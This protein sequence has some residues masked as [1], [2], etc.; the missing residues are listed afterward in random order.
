MVIKFSKNISLRFF[1]AMCL[2]E[3]SVLSGASQQMADT[4]DSLLQLIRS[5]ANSNE[6]EYEKGNEY[7]E[8]SYMISDPVLNVL[9]DLSLTWTL[10][11]VNDVYES[12]GFY[13]SGSWVDDGATYQSAVYSGR[14][15]DC[16]MQDFICPVLGG[17]LT[18]GYGYRESYKRLHKGIDISVKVGDVVRAALP[19]I[20][21]RIGYEPGGYGH[22][23]ILVHSNGMET[24]YAHLSGVTARLGQ[25]VY[26]GDEIARGGN[27]GNSTG[28][29]L[30]FEVRKNGKVLDPM[31]VFEDLKF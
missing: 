20:V 3:A 30:H 12:A 4:D 28:P 7:N 24:R 9:S 1:I 15:P 8:D 13:E 25:R 26:A 19:G 14:L 31:L 10:D 29:H 22:F 23:L 18:S 5:V 16:D 2:F 6:E 11:L 27:T 17:K 21:G